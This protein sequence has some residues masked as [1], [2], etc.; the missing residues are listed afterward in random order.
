MSL[1]N[2][3]AAELSKMLNSKEIS[4]VELTK[5]VFSQ[6]ADVEEKV[7]AY[8]TLCEENALKAA[9]AV[10]QKRANGEEL[11]ALAG[12]PIAVK[13]NL[14]TDGIL[15]TCSSKML[16]NFVPPYNATVVDKLYKNDMII[17]GKTN[18]DEF[19]MGSSCETS[20]YKKTANP[21]DLSRVPGGSSGGSAAAV[22]AGEAI[23]SL[24]S[25]TG[26]SIR[27][28]AAFCGIVGLK[29]TYGSVSRY[30]LVAFASSLDQVGPFGKTCEDTAM[31]FNAIAGFDK[32]DATSTD[33]AVKAQY[34]DFLS[35]DVKG[36][37]IGI[38]A[39]FYGEGIDP[40]VAV[41][42]EAAAKQFE[43]MGATL[44]KINTPLAPSALSAY[45]IIACAEASSNLARFDGVKYG[46]R[47]E[48]Y[49]NLNEMYV[50]TRTEGFGEEVKRRIMLGT[51]VLSSGSFDAYY[52]KAK[53]FQYSLMN[54]FNTAFEKVDF[55]LTPTGPTTA[56]KFGENSDDPVKMYKSDIC[57][58][59]VNIAGL[60]GLSMPC[61]YDGNGMPIGMQLI[62]P[63]F[64]EDVL[65]SAGHAFEKATD[66]H[67]N[68]PKM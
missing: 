26:G 36:M 5:D 6:I 23:L 33:L 54:E 1:N 63:K 28:P 19:A 29:P 3:T 34:T 39:E 51:Y 44:V 38:P 22:A 67:F 55:I 8:V 32:M 20:Y 17:T 59:T 47:T 60:P 30:G 45:Y 31:L 11:S 14:C 64:A 18:M 68:V 58:V 12:I 49:T 57:T 41:A 66:Y 24:G 21:F 46:Y 53:A 65:L 35:R 37:R 43:A 40:E 4:A 9:Q 61:G 48:N 7:G 13:D 2:K 50:N 10:D 42:V 56:F 52:K 62:A 15:T 25:D 27:Q 16:Y